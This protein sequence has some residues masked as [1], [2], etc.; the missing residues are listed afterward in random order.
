MDLRCYCR[1]SDAVRFCVIV[2]WRLAG[3]RLEPS[4]RRTKEVEH[5][6]VSELGAAPT[7][8]FSSRAGEDSR[9]PSLWKQT[10]QQARRLTLVQGAAAACSSVLTVPVAECER[11][12]QTMPR[13]ARRALREPRFLNVAEAWGAA[14]WANGS[15]ERRWSQSWLPLTPPVPTKNPLESVLN[16]WARV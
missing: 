12:H 8:F 13:W 7:S 5:A 2:F 3:G 10:V 9:Y 11:Q 6:A 1:K 4:C 15:C 16:P 14:C